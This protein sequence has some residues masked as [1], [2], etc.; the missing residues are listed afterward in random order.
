MQGAHAAAKPVAVP[1]LVL[2]FIFASAKSF[3]A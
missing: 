2:F 1:L 3:V